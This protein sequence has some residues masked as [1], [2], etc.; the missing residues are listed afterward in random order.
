MEE[1]LLTKLGGGG[2]D[3]VDLLFYIC[4]PVCGSGGQGRVSSSRRVAK[5]YI[6]KTPVSGGGIGG[7]GQESAVNVG[8]GNVC[9]FI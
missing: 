8:G 6:L 1:E 2:G 7:E 9:I 5:V 3:Y 4:I